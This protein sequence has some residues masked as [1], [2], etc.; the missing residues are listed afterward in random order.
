MKLWFE[1]HSTSLDNERGV[2][3]GHL[4]VE[5]SETGRKQ[6]AE[7]GERYHGRDLAAV[8]TS[9][10]RRSIATAEIAFC[11]SD[12]PRIIDRRLRECDYGAWSGCPVEQLDRQRTGFTDKPFPAGESYRDVV[13]RTDAFLS[14]LPRTVAPVLLIAHRAQ[15]YALEH[16][17]AHRDLREVLT[18]SWKWQPGWQYEI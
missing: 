6:A 16:L 10:L 8:Y 12:V 1:T 7:L 9:D 15:W 18:A 17:L 14:D 3:S 11:R 13:R 5:L 4:D 2:A